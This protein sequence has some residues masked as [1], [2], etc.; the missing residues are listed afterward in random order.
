M[1]K[2][3]NLLANINKINNKRHIIPNKRLCYSTKSDNKIENELNIL[4]NDLSILKNDLNKL[5]HFVYK[6]KLNYLHQSIDNENKK[7]VESIN[8]LKVKASGPLWIIIR[9]GFFV[10]LAVVLV[11]Y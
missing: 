3:L 7:I 4:K 5:D 1:I 9:M 11:V 10:L 6:D 8:K 2:S